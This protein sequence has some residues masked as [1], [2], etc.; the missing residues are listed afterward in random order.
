MASC[1]QHSSAILLWSQNSVGSVCCFSV[2]LSL[3]FVILFNCAFSLQVHVF[4]SLNPDHVP[5]AKSIQ[6]LPFPNGF[7]AFKPPEIAV[8]SLH[9]IQ[10]I[11]PTLSEIQ[12]M[13]SAA[14][15]HIV[16]TTSC[17]TLSS[18]SLCL[19]S[20]LAENKMTQTFRKYLYCQSYHFINMSNRR[21]GLKYSPLGIELPIAAFEASQ[22]FLGFICSFI[23]ARITFT[24]ILYLQCIHVIYII[25]TSQ[26]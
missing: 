2:T 26:Y 24:C 15:S 3:V 8:Y 10:H 9:L 16:R 20:S 25:Y 1:E 6:D 22:F 5:V 7:G 21:Q 18:G 17:R 23:T 12:F 11:W 4:C 13:F 19:S 14:A